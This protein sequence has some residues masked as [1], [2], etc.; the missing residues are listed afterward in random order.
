MPRSYSGVIRHAT[1]FCYTP[2]R[3]TSIC[4]TSLERTRSA[5]EPLWKT[6]RSGLRER[7][8]SVTRRKQISVQPVLHPRLKLQI[9]RDD[10]QL[11]PL[12]PGHLRLYRA[13][14][15]RPPTVKKISSLFIVFF[16]ENMEVDSV[17]T[18]GVHVGT[19][20]PAATEQM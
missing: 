17:V 5:W 19:R 6:G 20:A 11:L 16:G 10:V 8:H 15:R 18:A 12:L 2:A 9:H 7:S 13:C 1:C 14:R 4:S 3:P